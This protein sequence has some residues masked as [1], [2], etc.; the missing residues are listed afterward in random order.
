MLSLSLT[1]LLSGSLGSYGIDRVSCFEN[2]QSRLVQ[3]H[4]GLGNGDPYCLLKRGGG[5]ERGREG[6][7]GGREGGRE[8]GK[9]ERE[10]GREREGRREGGRQEERER[11]RKSSR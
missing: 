2:Q 9:E 8:G 5:R 1:D 6:R 10:G 3:F 11:E 7:K 4:S